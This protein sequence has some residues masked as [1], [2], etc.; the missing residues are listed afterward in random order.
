M[1]ICSQLAPREPLP[2][3][4]PQVW[5]LEKKGGSIIGGTLKLMQERKANPPPPRDPRLP[6]KPKVRAS[7]P[8][9]RPM[10]MLC[11]G[12]GAGAA[13]WGGGCRLLRLLLHRL[14][15]YL[16]PVMMLAV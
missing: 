10:G 12:W 14:L 3:P 9:A 8:A 6:P 2:S 11:V 5:E 1:F 16:L 7:Q 4:A 13:C 15:R